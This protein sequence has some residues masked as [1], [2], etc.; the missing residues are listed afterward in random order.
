M[1]ML[2]FFRVIRVDQYQSQ[3]YQHPLLSTTYTCGQLFNWY[4][5]G[6]FYSTSCGNS[7]I[8]HRQIATRRVSKAG[9]YFPSS[10]LAFTGLGIQHNDCCLLSI[11]VGAYITTQTN[12]SGTPAQAPCD[13]P[14]CCSCLARRTMIFLLCSYAYLGAHRPVSVLVKVYFKLN[15]IPISVNS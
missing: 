3:K 15:L 11:T 13:P 8:C 10:C 1:S 12:K 7:A 14:I 9:I 2:Y 6:C 5:Q 4:N